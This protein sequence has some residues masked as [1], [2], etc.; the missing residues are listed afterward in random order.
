MG[1][2]SVAL[3]KLDDYLPARLVT[4]AVAFDGLVGDTCLGGIAQIGG[5]PE[6]D[7]PVTI[8]VGSRQRKVARDCVRGFLKLSVERP[9]PNERISKGKEDTRNAERMHIVVHPAVRT[10]DVVR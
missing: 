7:D 3:N 6:L 8:A 9:Q 10:P 2:D 1:G 4:L 5:I